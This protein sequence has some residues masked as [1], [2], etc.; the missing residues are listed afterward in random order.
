MAALQKIRSKGGLLIAGLGLALFA[1]IAEEFFRSIE[2]TSAI[3][4]Q[5]VGEVYG[6]KLSVQDFQNMVEEASEVVKIQRQTDNLSD[7][8]M[9]S[10]RQQVWQSYVN[11]K[12]IEHETEKFGLFVTDEDVQNTLREGRA[13]SLMILAPFFGNQNGQFDLASLQNFLKQYDQMVAQAAQTAPQQVEQLQSIKKLW[14][15]AEK[16]LR[17][18]ILRNKFYVLLAQS[19]ISN[20]VT[21][22]Y[23]FEARTEQ[24]NAEIA[25]VPYSTIADKDIQITDSELKAMYEKYKENFLTTSETRDIKFIDVP[26]IASVADRAALQKEVEAL[27]A[28]LESTDDVAAVVNSSKT[29]YPYSN[30]AMSKAAFSRMSDISAS[31][32]SMATGSVKGTYYN[33]AD[34][35]MNTYKLVSK[36]QA[37]D[38]VLCRQIFAPAESPEK[39]KVLADSIFKALQGGADFKTLAKKYQQPG[40]SSWAVSSQYEGPGLSEDNAKLISAINT[41]PTNG[42]EVVSTNQGSIVLQVLDR[43]AMTTKYNVAIIKCPLEFSKT[44]YNDALGKINRFLAANRTLESIEK[45]AGKEG[46]LVRDVKNFSSSDFSLQQYIGG[47]GTKEAVR[48]IFDEAEKGDISK[49]YECGR[50]NDH[51]LVVAV[52]DIYKQGYLPWDNAGVKDFLTKLVLQDKKGEKLMAQLKNVKSIAEAKKQKGAVVE[53]LTGVTLYGYPQLRAIGVSEPAVAGAVSK[54]GAGKYTGPVKGAAGVYMA[55]VSGKNK[56]VEK[57]DKD[58]EML[59][60]AQRNFRYVYSQSYNGASEWLI[61]YLMLKA[62]VVDHRYKF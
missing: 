53:N 50:N 36:I 33:A 13:Q 37:P 60:T 12:I 10:I 61:N 32:D 57:F 62:D 14:E 58:A 5:Q 21:A 30:L 27:Q 43:R 39:S 35:T 15:Y 23:D 29:A 31:L 8:D 1:F 28:K 42:I 6:E 40:D 59:Q 26:V 55:Q 18:E 2:T 34:N 11:N 9:E 19:F 45:N 47:S 49:L 54:T 44:T 56:G 4:K 38:S 46:Y 52:S 7:Q 16:E 20:P 17:K 22:K 24:S 25:A 48:W 3:N 41:I 51:L